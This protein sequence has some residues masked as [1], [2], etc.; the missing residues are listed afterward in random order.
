MNNDFA[1]KEFTPFA[2]FL[3]GINVG[4]KKQIKMDALRE[5][6]Q[7]WGFENVSTILASGNILFD[8]LTADNQE[9]RQ[10]ITAGI[11]AAFGFSADVFVR[12]IEELEIL[13]AREPFKGIIESAQTKLYV[14]F[15]NQN[16]STRLSIP[17]QSSGGELKIILLTDKE[18]LSTVTLSPHYGTTNMMAFLEKEFGSELTTRNWNT[19]SKILHEYEKTHSQ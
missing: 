12:T 4:G 6:F 7:S 16:A 2:A 3:R 17:Y 19:V 5:A 10:R 15:L 13:A 1:K 18:V 8:A 11:E 14:T 9:T